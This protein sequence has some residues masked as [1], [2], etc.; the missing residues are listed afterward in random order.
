VI[1]GIDGLID[2]KFTVFN[3]WGQVI[4]EKEG[5]QN[6]WAGTNQ[7]GNMMPDGTYF[8]LFTVKVP[9]QGELTFKATVEQRQ[10]LGK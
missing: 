6:D 5:Y 2:N 3:R 10:N 8:I 1:H 4:Y 7:N 9:G